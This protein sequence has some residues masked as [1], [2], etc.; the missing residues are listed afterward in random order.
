MLKDK[1]DIL[2]FLILFAYL[3]F[4]IADMCLIS[5][6]NFLSNKFSGNKISQILDIWHSIKLTIKKLKHLYYN[7]LS[8]KFFEYKA[9]WN[10]VRMKYSGK[11]ESEASTFVL[12]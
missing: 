5:A 2:L 12:F 4:V 3:I 11:C 6:V 10:I 9:E 1:A 8:N 7:A